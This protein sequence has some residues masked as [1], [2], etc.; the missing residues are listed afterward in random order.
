MVR[1]WLKTRFIGCLALLSHLRVMWSSTEKVCP[2]CLRDGWS[3]ILAGWLPSL[4]Q[5]NNISSGR[6]DND[7][8]LPD[9]RKAAVVCK[10]CCMEAVLCHMAPVDRS[11][12]LHTHTSAR[13]NSP[14]SMVDI[15]HGDTAPRICDFHM[16][17]C[18]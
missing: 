1:L 4:H 8:N 10:V 7:L 9:D 11:P 2:F 17:A 5:A 13:Q 14:A 15:Y 3:N 16:P 12:P 18:L 6:R